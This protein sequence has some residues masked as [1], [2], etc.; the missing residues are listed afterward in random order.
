MLFRSSLRKCFAF[1]ARST[2]AKVSG[3]KKRARSAQEPANIIDTQ[4]TQ[5]QPRELVV[6]LQENMSTGRLSGSNQTGNSQTT[7]NRSEHRTQENGRGKHTRSY[8]PVHGIPYV[9]NDT[10]AVSEGC[11]TEEPAYKSG[12]KQS[13]HVVRA[14]LADMEDGI[15]GESSDKDGSSAN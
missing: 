10:G 5:R 15:H 11:D 14:G 13:R 2:G 6:I 9:R 7:N 12:D 3:R 8:S 1:R 4:K